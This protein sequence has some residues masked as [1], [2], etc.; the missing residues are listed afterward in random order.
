MSDLFD[1]YTTDG[2]NVVVG[3]TEAGIEIPKNHLVIPKSNDSY[4]STLYF[5]NVAAANMKKNLGDY[6]LERDTDFLFHTE[7]E[8]EIPD[9]VEVKGLQNK[10]ATANK[11]Y[12]EAVANLKDNNPDWFTTTITLDSSASFLRGVKLKD[13]SDLL[14]EYSLIDVVNAYKM[15]LKYYNEKK[16]L[17][18]YNNT[19]K[20]VIKPEYKAEYNSACEILR[21]QYGVKT[22]DEIKAMVKRTTKKQ[23]RLAIDRNYDVF[24]QLQP[25]Y[26][27]RLMSLMLDNVM[28]NEM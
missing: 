16:D 23:T 9:P 19:E 17:S 21:A 8:V 18:E 14:A 22:N 13:F 2:F 6:I 7:K 26:I 12:L 5:S 24:T 10:Q 3:V 11:A 4:E 1:V 27:E 15:A 28:K 25:D 20:K